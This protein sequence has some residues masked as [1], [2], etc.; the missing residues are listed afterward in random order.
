MN[1]TSALWAYLMHFVQITD[2]ENQTILDYG[3][4][5]T[6]SRASDKPSEIEGGL[7]L[8]TTYPL[9]VCCFTLGLYCNMATLVGWPVQQATNKSENATLR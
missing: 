9:T 8:P 4:F 7:L 5:C 3:I 6:E 1:I 2:E